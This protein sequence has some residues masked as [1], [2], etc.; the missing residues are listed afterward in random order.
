MLAQAEKP[1]FVPEIQEGSVIQETQDQNY[2]V[3]N[4]FKV[5]KHFGWWIV[6]M[7]LSR[8]RNVELEIVY[9][10][11]VVKSRPELFTMDAENCIAPEMPLIVN[12]YKVKRERVNYGLEHLF[13]RRYRK[14]RRKV[15]TLRNLEG[16]DPNPWESLNMIKAVL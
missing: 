12:I 15:T 5:P 16:L 1:E 10:R 6:L 3:Y 4:G 2:Y 11:G 13:G 9:S 8:M 14:I 7:E